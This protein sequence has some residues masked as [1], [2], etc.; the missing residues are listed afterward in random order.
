MF[1]CHAKFQVQTHYE[2]WAMKKINSSLNSD[3]TIRHYSTLICLFHSS[4]IVMCFNL[5]F[6][7]AI[8]H[9]P[10][11]I[12]HFFQFFWNFKTS[13]SRGFHRFPPNVGFRMISPL[14]ARSES[15]ILTGRTQTPWIV[16]VHRWMLPDRTTTLSPFDSVKHLNGKEAILI[17]KG[18]LPIR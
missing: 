14:H 1:H 15:C 18:W 13:F 12:P 6:C 5:K 2:M 8:K 9:H 10:L 7:V 3:I 17:S 11:N 16:H 4:H